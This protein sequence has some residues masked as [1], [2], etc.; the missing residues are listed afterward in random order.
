M[1]CVA[2]LGQVHALWVVPCRVE[3]PRR[4]AMPP[5]D[6]LDLPSAP[7]DLG[8]SEMLSY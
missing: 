4:N 3:V 1:L 2:L 7:S 8:H 6:V 5:G